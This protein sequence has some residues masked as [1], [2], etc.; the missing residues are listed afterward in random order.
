LYTD[1]DIEFDE[2]GVVD[3]SGAGALY[4]MMGIF[5]RAWHLTDNQFLNIPIRRRKKLM[6][7]LE[8]QTKKMP[9]GCP[10]AGG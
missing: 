1:A 9:F 5:A 6:K 4:E 10:F 8:W 7:V 3:S 2:G